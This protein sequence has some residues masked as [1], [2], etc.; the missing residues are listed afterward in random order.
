MVAQ[1][2]YGR[3]DYKHKKDTE[4]II[5]TH[6][7]EVIDVI[8]TGADGHLVAV[9]LQPTPLALKNESPKQHY[10]T[11]SSPIAVPIP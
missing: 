8:Q 6:Q 1:N 11:P 9:Q 2:I 7:R 5:H 4:R 10:S 3:K